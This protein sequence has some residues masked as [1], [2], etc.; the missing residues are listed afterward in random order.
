MTSLHD[1]L[2]RLA[3][4]RLAKTEL[5]VIHGESITADL[6]QSKEQE[7][8]PAENDLDKQLDGHLG[9]IRQ[10]SGHIDA[11]QWGHPTGKE[12]PDERPSS[13]ARQQP[14]RSAK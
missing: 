5:E 11:Q 13:G 3:L 7:G 4:Q 14:R 10:K 8:Q 9:K 12:Q 1:S 6:S 2:R